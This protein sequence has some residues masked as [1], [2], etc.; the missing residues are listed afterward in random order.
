MTETTNAALRGGVCVCVCVQ[1]ATYLRRQDGQIQQ[2]GVVGGARGGPGNNT[3]TPPL[4]TRT[5]IDSGAA[6]SRV[7]VVR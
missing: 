3:N 2:G 7:G 5:G 4:P 6:V 1:A